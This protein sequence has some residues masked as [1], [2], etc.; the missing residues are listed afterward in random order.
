MVTLPESVL[1]L[2]V[3]SWQDIDFDYEMLTKAEKEALPRE[4]FQ[5]IL[6]V[7]KERGLVENE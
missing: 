5:A 7:L 6:A 1:R 2:L 4:D 3:Y